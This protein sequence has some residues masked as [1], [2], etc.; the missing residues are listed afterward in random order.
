VKPCSA[1]RVAP[2][3]PK[4]PP[5]AARRPARATPGDHFRQGPSPTKRRW[6]DCAGMWAIPLAGTRRAQAV[7]ATSGRRGSL[8]Y[9]TIARVSRTARTR[10]PSC[11]GGRGPRRSNSSRRSAPAL[12]HCQHGEGSYPL[13]THRHTCDSTSPSGSHSTCTAI[14]HAPTVQMCFIFPIRLGYRLELIKKTL[15]LLA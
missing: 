4:P 14:G 5:P 2:P 3:Q 6:L 13:S 1:H 10:A 11:G 15:D 8:P 9:S 12:G 7:S